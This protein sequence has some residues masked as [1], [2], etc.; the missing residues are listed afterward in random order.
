MK[1]EA[2]LRQVKYCAK[3]RVKY[4]LRKCEEA[5]ISPII[6][7]YPLLCYTNLAKGVNA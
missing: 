3:A 7:T 5:N 1:N 4:L 2:G 6:D